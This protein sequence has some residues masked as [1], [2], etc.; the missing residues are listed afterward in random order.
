VLIN[1]AGFGVD[2][3]IAKD[4]N[5]EPIRTAD[6]VVHE[7][8]VPLAPFR[9]RRSPTRSAVSGFVSTTATHPSHYPAAEL[10]YHVPVVP[11][12]DTSR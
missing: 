3:A 9:H 8:R 7:L 10:E 2:G 12:R 1:N 11:N 5:P 6:A 4:S